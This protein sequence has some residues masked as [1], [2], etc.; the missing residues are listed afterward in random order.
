MNNDPCGASNDEIT[1]SCDY[2]MAIDV[3][4]PAGWQNRL[5]ILYQGDIGW[6][7]GT[8]IG[9][10]YD[11]AVR[12]WVFLSTYSDAAGGWAAN[13]LFFVE[14]T[15]AAAG[16]HLLRVCPTL[17]DYQGYWSEAFASLDFAAR[18]VWWGAN[19]SGQ[20]RLQ[21]YRARLCDGW[22]RVLE[23]P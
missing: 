16:P 6:G 22:W 13:Q 5:T 7:I 4:D 2:L 11:P 18:D 10:I 21:L 1:F 17:N 9:R 3:N 8:H 14:I 23:G 20:A 15:D 12:G 19:W